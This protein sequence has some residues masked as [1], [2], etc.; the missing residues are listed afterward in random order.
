MQRPDFNLKCD[1]RIHPNLELFWHVSKLDGENAGMLPSTEFATECGIDIL[2]KFPLKNNPCSLPLTEKVQF[3][4]VNYMRFSSIAH[5]SH[6]ENRVKS[7][8]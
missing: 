6:S 8:R 1:L 3:L 4:P 2:A 7:C 5:K